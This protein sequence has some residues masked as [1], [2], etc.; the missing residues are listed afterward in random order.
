MRLQI[1]FKYCEHYMPYGTLGACTV[2]SSKVK[3]R[4][5]TYNCLVV[6]YKP[7]THSSSMKSI[8]CCHHSS[9]SACVQL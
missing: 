9:L 6:C 8:N 5:S 1:W 2:Q 3:I 7:V 4:A